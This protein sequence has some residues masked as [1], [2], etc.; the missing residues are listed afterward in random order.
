MGRPFAGNDLF[1][2]SAV[3]YGLIA[4]SLGSIERGDRN[5]TLACFLNSFCA[6]ILAV[7]G[8][9]LAGCWQDIV[10]D[11]SPPPVFTKQHP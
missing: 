5:V 4:I 8:S 10:R 3:S 6:V 9:V 1:R 11:K 2:W 7:A